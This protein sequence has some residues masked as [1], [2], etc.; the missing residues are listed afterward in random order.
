MGLALL[1]QPSNGDIVVGGNFPAHTFALLAYTPDGS[2]GFRIRQWRRGA[3][4]GGRPV[5]VPGAG[6]R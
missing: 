1:I 5:H 4:A 2:P 6:E 3:D